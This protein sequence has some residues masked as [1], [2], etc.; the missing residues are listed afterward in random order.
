MF[1]TS[2]VSSSIK[3]NEELTQLL[4]WTRVHKESGCKGKVFDVEAIDGAHNICIYLHV[5]LAG[6]SQLWIKFYSWR[7]QDSFFVQPNV[8]ESEYPF[9]WFERIQ[10]CHQQRQPCPKIKKGSQ[11][12]AQEYTANSMGNIQGWKLALVSTKENLNA[13]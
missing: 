12:L 9:H 11:V 10:V 7:K 3:K 1:T 13:I 4:R 6:H 2:K 5:T 8:F